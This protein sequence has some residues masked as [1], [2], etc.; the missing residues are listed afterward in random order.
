MYRHRFSK[1]WVS[2]QHGNCCY[3]V[4]SPLQPDVLEPLWYSRRRY[5]Y[6]Q[7]RQLASNL[8]GGCQNLC[9]CRTSLTCPQSSKHTITGE[10]SLPLITSKLGNI[11]ASAIKVS[12]LSGC[13]L[14]TCPVER[15]RPLASQLSV[16][17]CILCKLYHRSFDRHS[18]TVPAS[19]C[20]A[21]LTQCRSSR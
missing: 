11:Q 14:P 8:D 6:Q 9:C 15:L 18:L 12:R 2:N 1:L 20:R 17:H 16:A 3:S 5:Q 21:Q 10:G 13:L 7:W 19:T 4:Q